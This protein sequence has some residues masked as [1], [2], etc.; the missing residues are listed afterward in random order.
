[1]IYH[2]V[3]ILWDS[4]ALCCC[5]MYCVVKI[6]VH[7]GLGF[8]KLD[9]LS[10][11]LQF[12]STFERGSAKETLLQC[13]INKVLS[14]LPKP[15]D[16]IMV[17]T[18]SSLF[19]KVH[20]YSCALTNCIL[21][22]QTCIQ[23]LFEI[24]RTCLSNFT[25]HFCLFENIFI[26]FTID[27]C[28]V[29]LMII[30]NLFRWYC[31]ERV[32]KCQWLSKQAVIIRYIDKDFNVNYNFCITNM[33]WYGRAEWIMLAEYQQFRY[34]LLQECLCRSIFMKINHIL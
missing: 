23:N 19:L 26:W 29:K 13:V 24:I 16:F 5:S 12:S 20:I 14:F 30:C 10:R 2:R 11:W 17:D 25:T 27:Q 4:R 6:L 33:P 34:W 28:H 8:L 9:K 22:I 18:E 21:L 32:R 15:I 1:M 7:C 3:V 31:I